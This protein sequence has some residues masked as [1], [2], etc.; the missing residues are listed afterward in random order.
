[1]A[2]RLP[3]HPPQVLK[4]PEI[5]LRVWLRGSCLVGQ[6]LDCMCPTCCWPNGQTAEIGCCMQLMALFFNLPQSACPPSTLLPFLQMSLSSSQFQEVPDDVK[7]F[8]GL[9]L[10]QP[11][12]MTHHVHCIGVFLTLLGTMFMTF[13]AF[14][15]DP[16]RFRLP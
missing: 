16:L 15:D 10:K 7:W 6:N 11:V 13:R 2:S 14:T 9:G 12:L 4:I 1:M 5:P 8:V 3:P